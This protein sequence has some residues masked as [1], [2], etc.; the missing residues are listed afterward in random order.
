MSRMAVGSNSC[1]ASLKLLAYTAILFLVISPI[2]FGEYRQ[3][4]PGKELTFPKALAA[5]PNYPLE[6][7]Y[8]TG[9][10]QEE[11]GATFGFE[12]TFFRVGVHSKIEDVRRQGVLIGHFAIT[13]DNGQQ[14]YYSEELG[15]DDG[16]QSGASTDTLQVWLREWLVV[17]SDGTL[18]LKARAKDKARGKDFSLS[19]ELES[20]KQPV[21]HGESGYSRKGPGDGEASY[22]I[23][24]TRLRGSGS[25][26]IGDREFN[27]NSASAWM[28]HEIISF[29][30]QSP[31]IG[32]QWFAIQLDNETELML[33]Y[34]YR[35]D[36]VPSQ[37]SKGSY[38][39]QAGVVTPLKLEEYSIKPTGAWR[40]SRTRV[41]YPSGWKIEVPSLDLK[42]EVLPTV[43]DQ[44]IVS[45]D[46]TG[47]TY[48][49]GRCLVQGEERGERIG[50]AAYVELVGAGRLY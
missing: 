48:W 3:V 5:H 40:S 41:E 18:Q 7:W 28:D 21:L 9:H 33:Y 35:G 36:N 45:T 34:I 6:W 30:P 4:M 2:A 37:Y 26:A 43:K 23:S 42:L 17:F 39:N 16:I 32:W 11:E 25:L 13:D 22:Y 10:L 50:G 46:T 29:A 1:F 31:K 12:L 47:M 38:I 20:T 44:E 15:R 49:E 19:L 27:I 24:L 14:F 8:F